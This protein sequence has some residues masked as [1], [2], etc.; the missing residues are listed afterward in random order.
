[1]YLTLSEFEVNHVPADK[2]QAPDSLSCRKPSPLDSEESDAEDYLDKFIGSTRIEKTKDL[3]GTHTASSTTPFPPMMPIPRSTPDT[4]YGTYD[5]H[6]SMSTISGI[7]LDEDN[8]EHNDLVA[9]IQRYNGF[10]FNPAYYDPNKRTG[11]LIDHTLLKSTDYTT[12]TGHEFED[13]NMPWTT[14]TQVHLGDE[15]FEVEITSY[16]Y[17]YMS[18]LREGESPPDLHKTWMYSG[19]SYSC[20]HLTSRVRYEDVNAKGEIKTISHICGHQESEPKGIWE[21]LFLYLKDGKLPANCGDMNKRQKFLKRA[22]GFIVHDER[23]WKTEKKGR[24]PRLVITDV[25]R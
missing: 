4:P 10:A 8:V 18:S 23:L 17:E 13:R 25:E 12:Y 6:T 7:G 3:P 2:H 15:S 24:S 14:W 16:G 5:T 9:Q 1:M 20:G 22:G 19:V 21:Q 11:S